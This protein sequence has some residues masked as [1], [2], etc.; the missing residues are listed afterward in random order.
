MDQGNI[1]INHS[2][3]FLVISRTCSAI[4][5]QILLNWCLNF[6]PIVSLSELPIELKFFH[7]LFLH[8][9]YFSG[10]CFNSCK[11]FH[12][13]L[14]AWEIYSCLQLKCER[15]ISARHKGGPLRTLLQI[16]CHGG[17]HILI[18]TNF[19]LEWFFYVWI[20][21]IYRVLHP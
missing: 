16:D 7:V 15:S 14:K 12:G 2:W 13:R 11:K 10:E 4:L 8:A 6:N 20:S 17:F 19:N 9:C 18:S 21:T 1:A 3:R 5:F